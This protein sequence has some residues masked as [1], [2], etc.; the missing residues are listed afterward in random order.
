MSEGE[1]INTFPER[2]SRILFE[3]RPQW[4]QYRVPPNLRWQCTEDIAVEIP[5]RFAPN[6]PLRI[7][8]MHDGIIIS[9]AG[10]HIHCDS[11]GNEYPEE[12]FVDQALEVIDSILSEKLVVVIDWDNG[13]GGT[14][15]TCESA[16]LDNQLQNGWPA[17]FIKDKQLVA[18]SWNGTYD[19]GTFD[20][21]KC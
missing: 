18:I 10:W 21:T 20:P 17:F 11:W 19:R 8:T 9:W 5:S 2:F 3:K 12:Q 6:C 13:P 16:D 4:E 14:G 1:S 7:E 15:G